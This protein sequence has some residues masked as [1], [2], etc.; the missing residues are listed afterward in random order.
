M[1]NKFDLKELLGHFDNIRKNIDGIILD[2]YE[3][4]K[5][6]KPIKDG[7][8]ELSKRHL[9]LL[10]EDWRFSNWWIMPEITKKDLIKLEG[11]FSK[12][13][14]FD[15]RIIE[16][17]FNLIKNIEIVSCILRFINPENYAIFS[18][19][20]EN[21]LNIRGITPVD[22]YLFYLEDLDELKN[23]YEF[24]RI[25][26]VDMALWILA[27]IIYH[28]NLRHHP[29]YSEIYENYSQSINPIKKIMSRNSLLKIKDETPLYKADLLQE[30]DP[31][32]AGILACVEME[33]I[34]NDLCA[35]N[36]IKI[37]EK[38][39][40]GKRRLSMSDKLGKLRFEKNAIKKDEAE[41]IEKW[42]DIRHKLVHG[43]ESEK[44]INE[45]PSMIKGIME[46]QSEYKSDNRG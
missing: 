46:F 11:K 27:N 8:E 3:L 40:Y 44:E 28:E 25:A 20:V 1:A 10:S 33:K 5:E 18:S 35:T 9:E 30:S 29:N 41:D 31:R 23:K 38:K 2:V 39:K 4:E 16:D 26:E 14:P 32:L 42:W 13:K 22:K 36:G 21:L 43:K 34:V 24:N 19:P 37:F 12:L 6:F 45:V 7:K 15:R 17:L